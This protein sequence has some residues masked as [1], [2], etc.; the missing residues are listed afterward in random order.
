MN[1]FQQPWIGPAIFLWIYM[2][3]VFAIAVRR[4]NNGLADIAWGLGFGLVGLAAFITIKSAGDRA[5]LILVLVLV[6]GIRLAVYL[7]LRNRGRGEDWRYAAWRKEWGRGWLLRSYLQVFML[8]GVLLY[9]I[10]LPILLSMYRNPVPLHPVDAAGI[11]LWLIGFLFEAIAD[12]QLMRFKRKSSGSGRKSGAVMTSGLW[13]YS[14]HPNYFGEALLWWGIAFLAL[15]VGPWYLVLP[16]PILITY[17]L[18]KV[19]GVPMLERKYADNPEYREY[20]RRTSAF[21]PMPP[22]P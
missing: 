9:I 5:T 21:I 19:S 20:V 1:I 4:R 3:L 18:L 10:A 6:W 16:S 14:R 22:K 2:S 12:A 17:L 11:S 8:Q 15:Q 13:R 7:I